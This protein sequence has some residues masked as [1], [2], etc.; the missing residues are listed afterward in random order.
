MTTF[1][2]GHPMLPPARFAARILKFGAAA[3]AL[4]AFSLAVGAVGYRWTEGLSW[5]DSVY[6]AAMIL[7]GMGP[8]ATLHT[9][10]AKVFATCYALAS[11]LVLLSASTIALTPLVHRL[12]HRFH[13][14]AREAE[15]RGRGVER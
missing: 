6:N 1:R 7:T 5:L 4:I 13:L 10:G 15:A 12:L 2:L 3:S 11:S 9:D 8:V 14:E